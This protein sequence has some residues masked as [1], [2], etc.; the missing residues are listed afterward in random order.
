MD[1]TLESGISIF[2]APQIITMCSQGWKSQ[3]Q[4]LWGFSPLVQMFNYHNSLKLLQQD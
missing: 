3:I 1:N 2:K 4:N